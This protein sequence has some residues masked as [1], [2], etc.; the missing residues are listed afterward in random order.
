M[1]GNSWKLAHGEASGATDAHRPSSCAAEAP[2]RSLRAS[3]RQARRRRCRGIPKPQ[4][5]RRLYRS[6]AHFRVPVALKD[7]GAGC[8]QGARRS[9]RSPDPRRVPIRRVP[10][11]LAS[12]QAVTAPAW[13]AIDADVV[14]TEARIVGSGFG[15]WPPAGHRIAGRRTR[16]ERRHVPPGLGGLLASRVARAKGIAFSGYF[17]L[18][19]F[20]RPAGLIAAYMVHDGDRPAVG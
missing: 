1:G 9:F 2:G 16:T 5:S 6:H 13:L 15:R 8:L 19:V 4:R 7:P 18:S 17:S 12:L 3:A 20:S 14:V 10:C 11:L